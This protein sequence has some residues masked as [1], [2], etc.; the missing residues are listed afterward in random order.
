MRQRIIAV[1]LGV[2][3]WLVAGALLVQVNWRI[4]VG[5]FLLWAGELL[6]DAARPGAPRAR[7]ER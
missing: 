2:G 6:L 7:W 3:C 5:L 4:A 1:A